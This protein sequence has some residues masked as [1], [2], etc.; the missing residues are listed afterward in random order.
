[1]LLILTDQESERGID[2]LKKLVET[3]QIQ[4]Y[5]IFNSSASEEID[6]KKS[7]WDKIKQ[8]N[9]SVILTAGN[10][11]TRLLLGLKKS[12]KLGDSVG[13]IHLR[14]W[15]KSWIIPIYGGTYLLQRGKKN[16]EEVLKLLYSI[17]KKRLKND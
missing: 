5:E 11:S 2:L 6:L 10:L 13:K 14:D 8:T 15:T 7:F 4:K 1:M 3:A 12:M 16:S 17:N 9:P